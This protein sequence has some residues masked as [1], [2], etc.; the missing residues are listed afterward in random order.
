M[1]TVA[2]LVEEGIHQEE[3]YLQMTV[4]PDE[5]E[6]RWGMVRGIEAVMIY[7]AAGI[8]AQIEAGRTVKI[9]DSPYVVSKP[10]RP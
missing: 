4:S 1:K 3:L 10:T 8:A 7:A 2:Q 5:D 6:R 9:P